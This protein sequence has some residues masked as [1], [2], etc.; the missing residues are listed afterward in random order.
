MTAHAKF[1]ASAAHRWLRCPASLALEAPYP[2][3]SSEFADEGTAAHELAQL[4]LTNRL[5]ADA[6]IGRVIEVGERSFTVDDDMAGYIQS[7]VDAVRELADGHELLIEQRLNYAEAIGVAQDEG[8]GTADA[9]IVRTDGELQVHDLK[10][11]RGVRVDAE[12]NEQLQLYALGAVNTFSLAYDFDRVRLFIHQPRLGHVSEWA[13][14]LEE[15]QEFANYAATRVVAAGT[16]PG[17]KQCRFCKAKAECP[18]LAQQV[19]DSVADDFAGIDEAVVELPH[20]SLGEKMAR[21]ELIE[22]WCKSVRAKV[23]AEL[24]AGNPVDGFKLVEGR[25]GPR[26]WSDAAEAEGALRAMRLKAEE[27]FDM[28]L[29]SP[30][31]AEKLVKAGA[32]GPRQWAKL[33]GLIRQSP[34]SPSVAPDSDKRPAINP[35]D[36]FADLAAAE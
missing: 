30:T 14:T 1:S 22:G 3:S 12:R 8:F 19:A 36:D 9:T 18:A 20:L 33:G 34:G 32:I 6:Y 11:G 28:K 26:Q 21:V 7:Y 13:C 23:E 29:I 35:A 24:L 15:L 5:D 2:E 16:T 31:T 27:M 25:R 10:Y 17:E 4:C